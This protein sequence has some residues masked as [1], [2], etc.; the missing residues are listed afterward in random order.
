MIAL[1]TSKL[2]PVLLVLKLQLKVQ[3][4]QL[5]IG[6]NLIS[7]IL[8]QILQINELLPLSHL[9]LNQLHLRRHQ[10]PTSIIIIILHHDPTPRIHPGIVPP[11]GIPPIDH[12]LNRFGDIVRP[13]HGKT[14]DGNITHKASIERI[15]PGFIPRLLVLLPLVVITVVIPAGGIVAFAHLLEHFRGALAKGLAGF[16]E[17]LLLAN[18]GP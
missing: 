5:H 18:V 17:G 13:L 2:L 8:Q 7:R 9:L 11:H 4:L 16:V 3:Q 12:R 14:P 15:I 1:I 6:I 10:H